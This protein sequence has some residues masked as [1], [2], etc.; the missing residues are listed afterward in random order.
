MKMLKNSC[1]IY[2]ETFFAIEWFYDENGYSQPY[3]YFLKVSDVQ[4]RKFLLLVKKM[5]DFGKIIAKTNLDSGKRKEPL[6]KEPFYTAFSDKTYYTF[7]TR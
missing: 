5:D 6:L 7:T 2:K 3:E 4:K 1:L